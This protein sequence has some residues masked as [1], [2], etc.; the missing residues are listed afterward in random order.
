MRIALAQ[1]LSGTDPAANLALVGEYTHRAAGAGARLVVFPEATMCRFGVPLA[2]IAEPVDGPWADGVRRIA[3]EANVTV[4]A[5]MF[6]PSGDGR[7]KNTLLVANSDDQAVTHYDK[8][9]LYD[10]FGF[11]ESRTVAPG[12]EPVVVGVDGVR[13]GLSVCYDIRFPE[14]YTEL[15]R[16]GAQLIAVCASWGAG[17]GKLDQWTLLAR[18]RALDSMSYIAA[19]GQADPGEI[20]SASGAPTGVGGSLVASPLGE[21]VAS[22]GAQPQLVLADIDVDRVAQARKT[23]AALSN[24]SDFAQVGRAESVG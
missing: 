24:R 18:A 10:A 23:I 13:V 22:A 5:G 21:V 15:A 11:T 2:P 17:P 3:T 6:T 7:V 4:I 16:R 20:L 8:I 14:L 9:H 19:A 12:R 1:I